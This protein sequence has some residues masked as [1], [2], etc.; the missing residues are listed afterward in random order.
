[1][2]TWTVFISQIFKHSIISLA[3]VC[4]TCE[5]TKK[6]NFF[7]NPYAASPYT[8]TIKQLSGGMLM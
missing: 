7:L 5:L 3:L 6:L 2:F 1:M 4:K 8:Y